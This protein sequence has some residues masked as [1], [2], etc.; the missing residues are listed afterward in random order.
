MTNFNIFQ[1][2]GG[3][4]ICDIAI[5]ATSGYT[6]TRRRPI[7]NRLYLNSANILTIDVSLTAYKILQISYSVLKVCD[8]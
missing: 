8:L 6:G 3:F 4:C 1:I 7:S 5:S 2:K